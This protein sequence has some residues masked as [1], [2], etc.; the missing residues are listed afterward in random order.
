MISALT[1]A[2]FALA[3]AVILLAGFLAGFLI[4]GPAVTDLRNA[5]VAHDVVPYAGL[6]R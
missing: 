6:P 2:R 3:A 4:A 5:C 1:P